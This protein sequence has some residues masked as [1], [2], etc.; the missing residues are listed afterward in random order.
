MAAFEFDFLWEIT[1]LLVMMKQPINLFRRLLVIVSY[2]FESF[3]N[4]F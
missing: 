4:G 3:H 2:S 1:S